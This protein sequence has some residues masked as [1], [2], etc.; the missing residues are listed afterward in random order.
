[1]VGLGPE[2]GLQLKGPWG[3]AHSSVGYQPPTR[4]GLVLG[5]EDQQKESNMSQE[6]RENLGSG[7]LLTLPLTELCPQLSLSLTW[8]TQATTLGMPFLSSAWSPLL[9]SL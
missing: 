3:S 8:I 2:R 4:A 6:P 1:M 9:H 7:V 5:T